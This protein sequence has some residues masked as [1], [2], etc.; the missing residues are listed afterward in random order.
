MLCECG[1]AD[2]GTVPYKRLQLSSIILLASF[3]LLHKFLVEMRIVSTN[4]VF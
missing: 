2:F 4:G 1:S 3:L